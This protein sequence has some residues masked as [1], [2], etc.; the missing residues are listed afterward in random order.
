MDH[1]IHQISKQ[2]IF[3][4]N[5]ANKKNKEINYDFK[6]LLHEQHLKLSKHA[7]ARL[8]ERNIQIDQAE[9]QAINKKVSEAK[10][11][12]VTDSLI[13][14]NQAALLVSTENNTVVTVMNV[15]E[16]KNRIFTNI[17]GTILLN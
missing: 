10:R 3:H 12:G 15:D 5:Q 14:L 4:L 16:A 13:V 1:R 6:A 17:N 11:K 7:A 2:H 8:S 9:W